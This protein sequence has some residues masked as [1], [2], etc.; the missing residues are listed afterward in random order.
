[1]V[2]EVN[3]GEIGGV[4]KINVRL[5]SY[6]GFWT[7]LVIP[8]CTWLL[9]PGLHFFWYERVIAPEQIPNE[10]SSNTSASATRAE[11]L[12][13]YGQFGDIFGSLNVLF[14]G[15][16]FSGVIAALVLQV[17]QMRQFSESTEKERIDR[18]LELFQKFRNDDMYTARNIAWKART[19]WFTDPNYREVQIDR[20]LPQT[21]KAVQERHE[22][23]SDS[24][25]ALERKAIFEMLEFYSMLAY[26]PGSDDILKSFNFYYP[27]WR[28][29]LK[30]FIEEYNKRYDSLKLSENQRQ[31]LPGVA[32]ASNISKLE[33][34]LGLPPYEQDKH[35]LDCVFLQV[36]E[37]SNNPVG[38]D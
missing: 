14:S 7:L 28:G 6:I 27:W 26:H 4:K 35:P 9:W 16:A 5:A 24:E 36:G 37:P 3:Y 22:E 10:V 34:R 32:W 17:Y 19:K 23:K 21:L 30:S 25:Q 13:K 8:I 15:L 2:V 33:E 1:V 11:D 12:D 29:F 20:L 31:Q 38:A 18:T